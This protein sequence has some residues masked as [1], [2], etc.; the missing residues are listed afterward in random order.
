MGHGRGWRREVGV[1]GWLGRGV[2]VCVR[3]WG[4][5]GGGGVGGGVC[6][7]GVIEREVSRSQEQCEC[8]LL[9]Q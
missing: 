8:H 2:V 4:G 1:G 3:W 6:G 5:G 9:H 7:K